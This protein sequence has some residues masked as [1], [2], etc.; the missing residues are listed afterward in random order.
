M[1]NLCEQVRKEYNLSLEQYNPSSYTKDCVLSEKDVFDAYFVLADY[2][3]SIGEM[4]RFGILDFRLLSSAIARQYVG[5]LET[6]KWNDSYSKIATL[7]YGLIKNHAFYDGNKRTAL[8]CILLALHKQ[9]RFIT[10]KKIELEKILVRIAANE[11]KLYK[12][13]CKYEKFKNDAAI[14]YLSNFLR[15]NSEPINNY[16]RSMTFEEFNKKLKTYGAWLDNPQKAYIDVFIKA[17]KKFLGGLIK[18]KQD[19]RV[20]HIAFPGWK[21]QIQSNT[22]K[23]VLK[24][25]GITINN[26]IDM[27]MFYKGAEPEY[28]LIDEYSEVLK[29]LKDK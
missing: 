12:D 28:K 11:M 20:M 25:I 22:I 13:Y 5:Y 19:R 29:R 10:C 16:S 8:L 9:K 18:I 14:M 1:N 27:R 15:K 21:R 23:S 7:V 2:F 26:G 24:A 3:I 6:K 4:T 17:K